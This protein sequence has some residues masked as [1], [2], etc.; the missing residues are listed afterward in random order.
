MQYFS[1]FRLRDGEIVVLLHPQTT[2]GGHEA[3]GF[4]EAL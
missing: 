2:E 1:K 4:C 3:R